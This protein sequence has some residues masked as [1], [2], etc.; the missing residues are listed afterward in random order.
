MYSVLGVKIIFFNLN[1]HLIHKCHL[2]FSDFW[3]YSYASSI[4]LK[5]TRLKYV[6][7]IQSVFTGE[8]NGPS[9][10]TWDV[11]A[12]QIK[13]VC[14]ENLNMITVHNLLQEHRIHLHSH[15]LK[16]T[17]LS[18]SQ[19]YGC[20]LSKIFTFFIDRIRGAVA[21]TTINLSMAPKV[22]FSSLFTFIL[23]LLKEKYLCVGFHDTWLYP[24][25]HSVSLWR[26]ESRSQSPTTVPGCC[27]S[28]DT[29][30]MGSPAFHK[31]L[32]T[33]LRGL[34]IHL[35]RKKLYLCCQIVKNTFKVFCLG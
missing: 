31:H 33:A 18:N 21:P 17:L 28:C 22:F 16:N 11:P 2:D 9:S 6:I 15:Y 25:C 10:A 24:P 23:T 1:F 3:I 8:N 4:F 34:L 30:S 35:N 20:Q 29:R 7:K 26:R 19:M 32:Y 12:K 5:R 13:L 27:C 14:T